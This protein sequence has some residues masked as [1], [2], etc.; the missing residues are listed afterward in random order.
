M[1]CYYPSLPLY[2]MQVYENMPR[3]PLMV[4][5]TS[6]SAVVIVGKPSAPILKVGDGRCDTNPED[7]CWGSHMPRS[8]TIG[9]GTWEVEN[10]V[11]S[12]LRMTPSN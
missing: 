7:F 5:R 1:P 6:P 10:P 2:E 12:D 8:L 4:G 3:D 9:A 11:I